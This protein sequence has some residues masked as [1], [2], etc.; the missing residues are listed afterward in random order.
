MRQQ[1]EL[2]YSGPP[3]AYY[4]TAEIA[5][6][7]V[8]TSGYELPSEALHAIGAMLDVEHERIAERQYDR[9]SEG[10]PP[11]TMRE[12]HLAAWEEKQALEDGRL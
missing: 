4:A 8:T 3:G 6:E 12:Q 10:E 2:T 11:V 9:R 1:I 5:G 7:D